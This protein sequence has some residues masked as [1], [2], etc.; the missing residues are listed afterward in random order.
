M[1]TT[2]VAQPF[3]Y[4]LDGVLIRVQVA[5]KLK[6]TLDTVP[7]FLAPRKAPALQVRH[8]EA[9]SSENV[10]ARPSSDPEM[11]TP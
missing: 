8:L 9:P 10:S 7:P 1:A 3:C 2:S 11:R 6:E 4:I 5:D